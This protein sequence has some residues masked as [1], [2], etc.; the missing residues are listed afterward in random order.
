MLL[1]SKVRTKTRKGQGRSYRQTTSV[2]SNNHQTATTVDQCR[3]SDSRNYQTAA[4]RR[5]NG[6]TETMFRLHQASNS[7][8]AQTA[9]TATRQ[10]AVRPRQDFAEATRPSGRPRHSNSYVRN[11]DSGSSSCATSC[12]ALSAR[13]CGSWR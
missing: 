7:C 8:E 11:T 5:N 1:R 12:A 10:H 4:C 2:A 6:Q 9:T 3:R 13:P